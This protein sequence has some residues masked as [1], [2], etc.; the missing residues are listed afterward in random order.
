VTGALLLAACTASPVI[1]P[2]R[3]AAPDAPAETTDTTVTTPSACGVGMVPVPPDAPAYCIDAFEV[4]VVDGALVSAA[5]QAPETAV[6]LDEATALCAA[7]PVVGDDGAEHGT[8]RLP[9]ADEWED[10]ADGTVGE[11]GFRFPYGDTADPS[12]CVTLGAGGAS[13]WEGVQPTGSM[14]ACVSPFGVFDAIGN[15]W[16]WTDSGLRVDVT[17]ALAARAA[18]GEVLDLDGDGALRLLEGNPWELAVHIAGVRDPTVGVDEADRLFLETEQVD[19]GENP[20]FGGG[21]LSPFDGLDD[22]ADFLPVQLV[23]AAGGYRVHL[24]AED[25]GA[26]VPDKRG[27]AWYAGDPEQCTTWA[28]SLEHTHDFEGTIGFRCVADPY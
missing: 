9:T 1:V 26:T 28:E 20:G 17:A 16:E 22:A 10:A 6:S 2:E 23:A 27:C 13:Q 7:T 3:P 12:A 8:K 15:A 25:D 18:D 19:G 21:Y 11:G 4:A 24:V 14:P 5:G